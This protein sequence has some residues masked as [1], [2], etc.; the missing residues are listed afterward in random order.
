M[1][2]ETMIG[3]MA[4]WLAGCPLLS[5][6]RVG[7]GYLDATAGGAGRTVAVYDAGAARVSTA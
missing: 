6:K 3:A 1:M 5:G 4:G 2:G 7:V